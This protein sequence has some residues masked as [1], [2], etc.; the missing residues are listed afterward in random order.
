M[1]RICIVPRVGGPGGMTSFRLKFEQGLRARGIDVTYALSQP[2]EAVLLIGGTRQLLSLWK[3]KRRGSRLVQRLDGINWV[4]RARWTGLRYHL[5]AE[6]GNAMLAFLRARFAEGVV[7]Q[8]KFIHQWWDEWYGAARVPASVILNGVDLIDYA[9]AGE[10]VPPGGFRKPPTPPYRLLV[11]EG[12]LAGGLNSGL[13][14]AIRLAQALDKRY[15]ME[16]VV[17]GR[18]DQRSQVTALKQSHVPLQFLG[19]IERQRV[20]GLMRS[21]HLLFSAEVNPP[22]PNSVIE[23]LACGLPVVGFDS[24]ALSELVAGDAGRVVPYGGNPWKL[25]PPDIPALAAAAAEILSDQPRFRQ[26]ARARA[27]S[28]LGVDRMVD[29][30]I[31]VLLD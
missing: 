24:G 10:T 18:V 19:V 2:A 13:F 4:Q 3:A 27:E 28:A 30:Y 16:I 5:R 14:S 29:Q 17:A 1:P 9:P 7:Y 25:D 6:Y 20:P 31:K 21:A 26:A 15:P 11:I 12:S 23:A 22:C 8:S